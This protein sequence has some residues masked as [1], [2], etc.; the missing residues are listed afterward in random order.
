MTNRVGALGAPAHAANPRCAVITLTRGYQTLA[1]YDT[2]IRRNRAIRHF[3]QTFEDEFD[4]VIFHTG[5]IPRA[6][7]EHIQASVPELPLKFVD[8][9]HV[10]AGS[11]SG[12]AEM[13]K[14]YFCEL[15]EFVRDYDLILRV[16]EDCEIFFVM[17]H[18]INIF[19]QIQPHQ[20]LLYA[21]LVAECHKPTNETLPEALQ[22]LCQRPVSS[23][24]NHKFPYVSCFMTRPAFWLQKSVMR[25]LRS[26]A[27]DPRQHQH[28]WSDM[29]ILGSILNITNAGAAPLR[30]LAYF[31]GSHR[32]LIACD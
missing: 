22:I 7:Q 13:C 6:H 17:D 2:L 16:D 19:A 20:V 12:Y 18:P 29:P 30:G 9:A 5:N 31:H 14:F 23:F 8:V 26:L 4:T 25:V 10:W 15:W 3:L 28:R 21:K 1:D 27:D 24:Y 11:G 32:K